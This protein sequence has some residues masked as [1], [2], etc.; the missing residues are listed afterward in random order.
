[1]KNLLLPFAAVTM[2]FAACSSKKDTERDMLFLS[3]STALQTN[4]NSDTAAI[5]EAAPEPEAPRA[6][7]YRPA[8]KKTT[9][10]R[11]APVRQAPE[12]VYQQPP[13]TQAPVPTPAPSPEP[14]VS[15]GTETAGTGTGT[16]SVPEAPAKKEGI[17]KAAKGAIIG[18]VAGAAAGAVISKK[19]KGA[20]IGGVVGAAGGY[21]LGRK[22]DKKDGR[23]Q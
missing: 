20:I 18:G 2:M 4:I 5:A 14:T 8:A 11:K 1:M 10:T 23:V 6:I 9:V 7:E 13:V 19:G 16:E 12:V 22:Q 3:D 21:I 17:S 15:T